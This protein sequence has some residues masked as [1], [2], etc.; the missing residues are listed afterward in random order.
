ML[1]DL[2]FESW[3]KACNV[4]L[5]CS[6]FLLRAL[7]EQTLSCFGMPFILLPPLVKSLGEWDGDG[8][9]STVTVEPPVG[10]VDPDNLSVTNSS[11][12]LMSSRPLSALVDMVSTNIRNSTEFWIANYANF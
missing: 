9:M 1:S 11:A 12:F 4:M 7:A 10:G 2:V 5:S 8:P 6:C 3:F